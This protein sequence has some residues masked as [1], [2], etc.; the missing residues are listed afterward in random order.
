MKRIA[1][2]T[3]IFVLIALWS[4]AGGVKAENPDKYKHWI[5]EEVA[6]LITDEEEK[7]FL[8]LLS[9]ADRDRF[10]AIFWA[11]RDPTPGTVKNEF[12]EEWYSRLAYVKKSFT[13]GVSKGW[14]SDQGRVYMLLGPPA[15]TQGTSPRNLEKSV[16]G[17]QQKLGE[18]IWYYQRMPELN[19]FSNFYVVF[20]EYQY[21][22]D[23][24]FL[25]DQKILRAMEIFPKKVIFSPDLDEL[26]GYGF[27]LDENSFEGRLINELLS[28]GEGIKSFSLELKPFFSQA[29]TGDTYVSFLAAIDP[30]PADTKNFKEIT[31]F[32]KIKGNRTE[33]DFLD[34]VKSIK[35]D[36]DRVLATFGLPAK[37]GKSI[38]FLGAYGNEDSLHTLLKVSLYIPEYKK[39]E[40]STSSLILSH[41]VK[42]TKS[43]EQ[44][45]DFDPFQIG[46]FRAIPRWGHVFKTSESLNVLY[47]IY[48]PEP[49]DDRVSLL[50]EYFLISEEVAY[51]LEPQDIQQKNEE[52]KA[53]VGGTQITLSPLKPGRYTF[54]I[55][56][57]DRYSGKAILREAD[58]TIE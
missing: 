53:I 48:N 39:G 8:S 1:R 51:K 30:R 55:K 44:E 52:G 25:T 23:L 33:Q 45:E 49:N 28:S 7:E 42:K 6:L 40:L 18:D 54:R 10:I 41:E 47:L 19:L 58:F 20:R 26:P 24:D 13:R 17:T 35:A 12:K 50:A 56:L 5:E 36:G 21:G 46:Q 11:R 43:K 57:T 27:I 29:T 4:A 22:Y 16:G 32:G 15:Q 37:P 9:D 38:L 2:V 14:R 34:S 31:F 3:G